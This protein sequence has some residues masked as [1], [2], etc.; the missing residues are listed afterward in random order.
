MIEDVPNVVAPMQKKL[1]KSRSQ[2]VHGQTS[3]EF[4][5]KD[6][7]I[8]V[9]EGESSI[10]GNRKISIEYNGEGLEK[11]VVIETQGKSAFETITNS[12][13]HQTEILYDS[14]DC[15]SIKSMSF[16][17]HDLHHRIQHLLVG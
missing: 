1:A 7:E 10:Y 14:C 12:L 13:K 11:N 4:N 15:C 5:V 6:V 8:V 17:C 2:E 9:N 3:S 16:V